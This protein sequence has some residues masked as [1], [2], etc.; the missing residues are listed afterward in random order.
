MSSSLNALLK[1]SET[2]SPP[3]LFDYDC[4]TLYLTILIMYIFCTCIFIETQTICFAC[5]LYKVLSWM[6][7]LSNSLL[8]E[9]TELAHTR[10]LLHGSSCDRGLSGFAARIY[11]EFQTVKKIAYRSYRYESL[12]SRIRVY[13]YPTVS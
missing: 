3:K 9:N 6:L 8:A 5:I 11:V 12:I 13:R 2:S 7:K 1:L 4:V 10:C